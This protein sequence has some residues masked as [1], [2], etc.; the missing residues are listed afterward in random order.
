MADKEE[1]QKSDS[2]GTGISK[3]DLKK[4]FYM[5][6]KGVSGKK[7]GLLSWEEVKKVVG[8]LAKKH[9]HDMSAE[10]YDT[11]KI[12]YDKIAEIDG[13]K[14]ISKS[15]WEKAIEFLWPKLDV[16]K[17]DTITF[18]EAHAGFRMLQ[19]FEQGKEEGLETCE[20]SDKGGKRRKGKGKK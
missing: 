9:D 18:C 16:N 8:N 6:D 12:A 15:D 11:L 5:I 14:E 7:D 17:D 19:S 1:P 2:C 20:A 3:K 4:T 10:E 13:K